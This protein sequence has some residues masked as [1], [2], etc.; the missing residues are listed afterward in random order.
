MNTIAFKIEKYGV[1]L[2]SIFFGCMLFIIAWVPLFHNLGNPYL[3]TWD[4][5]LFA[6]RA[7]FLETRGELLQNFSQLQ[8]GPEKFSVKPPLA[9]FIQS[10]SFRIF[11]YNLLSLRIPVAVFSFLTIATL[12]LYFSVIK[13]KPIA[14]FLISFVL[15]T[16]SGYID[17][18]VTRS[19]DH[20]AV[21]TFFLLC[22]ALFF[23]ETVSEDTLNSKNLRSCF[24]FL[25]LAFLVKSI[26]AFFVIPG[27]LIYS[28]Y[29]R[30]FVQIIR[31]RVFWIYSLLFFLAVVLFISLNTITIENWADNAFK[32]QIKRYAVDVD[33][34][35]LP[36]WW[37]TNYLTT[38]GFFP[39]IL[40]LPLSLML[41]PLRR[42][43]NCFSDIIIFSFLI[44]SCVLFVLSFSS[45]DHRWYLAPVYPFLSIIAGATIWLAYT[46]LA[47]KLDSS[48]AHHSSIRTIILMSVILPVF[49]FPYRKIYWKTEEHILYS[50][51]EIV[52]NYLYSSV[53]THS[54]AVSGS[55]QV[56]VTSSDFPFATFFYK[57]LLTE[58][59]GYDVEIVR[60][61][62]DLSQ[63]N[64]HIFCGDENLLT[65][66]G[67]YPAKENKLKYN[68]CFSIDPVTN[69]KAK[70]NKDNL[71]KQFPRTI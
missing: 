62:K 36:F 29:K 46:K 4:E 69:S 16:T 59:H 35:G 54:P 42:S 13:A 68:N 38:R 48:V 56:L 47:D 45:T 11:G 31:W 67:I 15:L 52:G 3:F 32:S 7:Y 61:A 57:T 21:L 43:K 19:G 55:L 60:S 44:S 9:T 30:R 24:V 50:E 40:I 8:G 39:W 64:V 49:V 58:K 70:S 1:R 34:Q 37:Y 10:M 51:D 66:L 27:F 63:G 71:I 17:Y 23:F 12:F 2:Q 5:S 14:G 28:L 26:S 41:I 20:D 53:I 65:Y 22:A 33:G 25:Y 18:H 6:L